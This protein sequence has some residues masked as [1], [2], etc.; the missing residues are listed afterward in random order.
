MLDADMFGTSSPLNLTDNLSFCSNESNDFAASMPTSV[1]LGKRKGMELVKS[2]R[3]TDT[4]S[5]KP[6]KFGTSSTS[7]SDLGMA[8]K[9]AKTTM[10]KSDLGM[11]VKS[12]KPTI[13][14][15]Q[16]SST[17]SKQNEVSIGLH[18]TK[19]KS[20]IRSATGRN[21]SP[22]GGFN[23]TKKKTPSR[24]ASRKKTG[25][26]CVK[27]ELYLSLRPAIVPFITSF[28]AQFFLLRRS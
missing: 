7:I 17:P 5:E 19:K 20:P 14:K 23:K 18:T 12:T 6:E 13:K 11:A 10:K 28:F 24:G 26:T 21:G 4:C 2:S 8:V 22:A 27:Y 16:S 25:M 3:E 9:N 1:N 15:S